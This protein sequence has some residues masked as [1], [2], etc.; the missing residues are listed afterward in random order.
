MLNFDS[1]EFDIEP[2]PIGIARNALPT[3]LYE[4][5][6]ETFPDVERF[7]SKDFNGVKYSLSQRNNKRE[8][9]AHVR[10]NAAWRRFHDYIKSDD[11]IADTMAMLKAQ[12]IDLGL[13]NTALRERISKRFKAFKKGSPQP[14]FS[15]LRSRFEFSAMPVT[16][17]SIRP[18]TDHPAKVVTMVIPILAEGEWNPAYGGGTS[19]VWPKDR[20]RVYNFT[21]EYMDFDEVECVKT[22]PFEPNQCLIFVKT[23][24]SWHAVWPMT[25]ND[26]HVLRKTLTINIESS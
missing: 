4:E 6:I 11:Y 17:G 24:N 1:V 14:H 5:L 7:V 12:Q 25:G 9:L 22:F 3:D 13:G 8:Y 10:K 16:G 21:N 19:I 20:R 15:T 23:H 26:Q 2:Y 18:H